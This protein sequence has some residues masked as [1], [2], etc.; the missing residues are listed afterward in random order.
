MTNSSQ[1]SK[2]KPRMAASAATEK[3]KKQSMPVPNPNEI[4]RPTMLHMKCRGTLSFSP[5]KKDANRF[6]NSS[7]RSIADMERIK[8]S[9]PKCYGIQSRVQP[10]REYPPMKPHA[11][12]HTFTSQTSFY[13][14]DSG[15]GGGRMDQYY[16]SNSANKTTS[17]F[18]G[19][20]KSQNGKENKEAE[21][22]K[23]PLIVD[24]KW[25]ELKE[26]LSERSSDLDVSKFY[27]ESSS[28]LQDGDTM[29]FRGSTDVYLLVLRS[30]H[31]LDPAVG[32]GTGR[33]AGGAG[34]RHH[35][36]LFRP[37]PW[38]SPYPDERTPNPWNNRNSPPPPQD[39]KSN[40]SVA[41]STKNDDDQKERKDDANESS[42]N[43]I[44]NQ[45]QLI[46]YAVTPINAIGVSSR[47]V[48]DGKGMACSS[49]TVKLGPLEVHM[50]N[51]VEEIEVYDDD[52]DVRDS[53]QRE[54][55]SR[56][57]TG[58]DDLSDRNGTIDSI[59]A[60][61]QKGKQYLDK[62]EKVSDKIQKSMVQ[63]AEFIRK[64]LQN[65]FMN[66]SIAAS[67]K[68]VGNFGKTL[69]QMEKLAVDIWKMWTDDG[70]GDGRRGGGF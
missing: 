24:T 50:A 45:N 52:D 26:Q 25:D 2:A 10:V 49:T 46:V 22:P 67:E 53:N 31:G 63:N 57:I 61:L 64:E 23:L 5:S 37:P 7:S 9:L 60:N 34:I 38:L 12:L 56:A 66:R 51:F 17:S 40:Q 6:I 65:D 18:G 15:G 44:D 19:R 69:K 32:P 29:N 48:K 59:M 11:A 62:V 16:N 39:K 43:T 36:T 3:N 70:S 30:A 58:Q 14:P 42:D 21:Q 47:E 27:S 4:Y 8:S 28:S 55:L 20:G 41:S 68:I 1:E 54:G 33:A 35:P 13:H